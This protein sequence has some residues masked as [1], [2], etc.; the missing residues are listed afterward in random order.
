M[1]KTFFTTL[2]LAAAIAFSVP[3]GNASAAEASAAAA[4]ELPVHLAI[5][6]AGARE[7]PPTVEDMLFMA[8]RPARRQWSMDLP[9][10]V[11]VTNGYEGVRWFEGGWKRPIYLF[12]YSGLINVPQGGDYTFYVRRPQMGPAY[13]LINGE[14]LV[15][16][17]NRG[18]QISRRYDGRRRGQ[19]G[20]DRRR[21][22]QGRQEPAPPV[23]APPYV[24]NGWIES[25][26][27]HLERGPVE[28][29]ALGFCEQRA[30]FG[31][32]WKM[33]GQIL[34]QPVSTSL[35]ARAEHMRFAEVRR[36]LEYRAAEARLAGVPSFCFPDDAVRP[37][38]H[39]RSNLPD[40]E[41]SVR[42]D[43]APGAA[44]AAGSFAATSSV[45]IV[46]GWGRLPT[47][48]WRAAD[49][50][51]ISWSVSGGGDALAEGSARFVHPPF[52][53]LPAGAAG[54]ALV[55][56]GTNL[57]YVSR[58]HGRMTNPEALPPPA[59][60]SAVFADGFGGMATNLLEAAL[61]RAFGGGAP[62][63]VKTVPVRGLATPDEAM[64][65]QPDLLDTVK[66]LGSAAAGDVIVLAPEIRGFALGEDLEDFER[67]LAALAGLVSE[68]AG[69][70]LVLVTPPPGLRAP[71]GSEDMRAYAAAVHRV[72]DAY[73]LRVADV[74]TLSRT[75]EGR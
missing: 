39:V 22:Q 23:S 50:S 3:P 19:Q 42:V 48:E 29:R 73:G 4:D 75:K 27:I 2:L 15:D 8:A 38:I 59:G 1:D 68:A 43:F 40:V 41:V 36:P 18:A 26:A 70:T 44:G 74:Y 21:G 30:D 32:R 13:L 34:P 66:W 65:A 35:F 31:L 11:P 63:I 60:S 47:G 10:I 58:R 71:G 20:G 55:T 52:D 72:A 5:R 67:R 54:D 49:C 64:F 45:H 53:A 69:R 6:P 62:R 16:F 24:T 51:G 57:V 28:F 9:S 14:A 33:A 25:A 46:R 12:E 61:S 56:G 37:E 7:A 17:P